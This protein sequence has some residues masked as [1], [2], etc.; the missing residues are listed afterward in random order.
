MACSASYHG[1]C[2]LVAVPSNYVGCI[3]SLIVTPTL[4]AKLWYR[5]YAVYGDPLGLGQACMLTQQCGI[6]PLLCLTPSW[7]APAGSPPDVWRQ[8]LAAIQQPTQPGRTRQLATATPWKWRLVWANARLCQSLVLF[9]AMWWVYYIMR[10]SASITPC[11]VEY[12]PSSERC[13]GS[14]T[15][16]A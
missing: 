3:H 6:A 10:V 11:C 12:W 4:G 13:G 9:L 14:A 5:V 1:H 7:Q 16:C 15:F 8:L 2:V